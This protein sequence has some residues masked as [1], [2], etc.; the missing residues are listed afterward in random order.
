MSRSS[1]PALQRR[2]RDVEVVE[3]LLAEDG[4]DRDDDERDERGPQGGA[5]A[6]LGLE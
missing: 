6:L 2:E 5:V 1:P 4:E 3:Q